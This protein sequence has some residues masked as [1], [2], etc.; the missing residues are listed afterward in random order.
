MLGRES[1]LRKGRQMDL[2]QDLYFARFLQRP[3]QQRH[4]RKHPSQRFRQHPRLDWMVQSRALGSSHGT[5]VA[6]RTFHEMRYRNIHLLL[7]Q[8][9]TNHPVSC[10]LLRLHQ[11][12]TLHFLRSL[13]RQ[14]RMALVH[15]LHLKRQEVGRLQ[16]PAP[17]RQSRGRTVF[18]DVFGLDW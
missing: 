12:R 13:K 15:R 7:H 3:Q 16:L 4:Q 1:H 2:R 14:R 10:I 17:P 9:R 8:T 18:D 6:E 11:D 5:R